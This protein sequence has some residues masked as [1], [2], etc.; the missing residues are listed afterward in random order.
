LASQNFTAFVVKP[1]DLGLWTNK[2]FSHFEMRLCQT[3]SMISF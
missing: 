3:A 2:A 1:I